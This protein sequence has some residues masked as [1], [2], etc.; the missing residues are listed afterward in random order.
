MYGAGEIDALNDGSLTPAE[1]KR[2]NLYRPQDIPDGLYFANLG[3][4]AQQRANRIDG[5]GRQQ[6]GTIER[7]AHHSQ[8]LGQEAQALDPILVGALPGRLDAIAPPC[9]VWVALAHG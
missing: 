4:W 1:A 2:L 7:R 6:S 5:T 9:N 8:Q 3:G